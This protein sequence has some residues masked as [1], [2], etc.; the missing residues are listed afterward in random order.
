MEP[1]R[2]LDITGR[3]NLMCTFMNFL[4]DLESMEDLR[5][6][7]GI[8]DAI[9]DSLRKKYPGMSVAGIVE[10]AGYING[11]MQSV[12]PE[13]EGFSGNIVFPVTAGGT[14]PNEEYLVAGRKGES[15]DRDTEYGRK[16]WE[17]VEL[18][19]GKATAIIDNGPKGEHEKLWEI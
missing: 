13:Y 3:F 4:Q 12:Y 7:Y 8:C 17:L 15:W 18:L 9:I 16:R 10:L 2:Q 11:F 19:I 1:G 5:E 6:H 14:S